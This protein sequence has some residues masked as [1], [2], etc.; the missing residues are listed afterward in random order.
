MK[1]IKKT[2]YGQVTGL[3]ISVLEDLVSRFTCRFID[4]E[5]SKD[6]NHIFMPFKDHEEQYMLALSYCKKRELYIVTAIH[7]LY[8]EQVVFEIE[9]K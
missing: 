9:H 1:I 6:R 3:N 2:V 5:W 4:Y 7:Y 8:A